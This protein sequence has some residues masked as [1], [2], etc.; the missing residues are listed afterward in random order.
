MAEHKGKLYGWYSAKMEAFGRKMAG[1]GADWTIPPAVFY[2]TPY[3][4][5]VK[6]TCVNDSPFDSGAMWDD[7]VPMGEV[8]AYVG[9]A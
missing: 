7:I 8:T 1:M 2:K 4:D 6:V 9:R 5:V 3:G